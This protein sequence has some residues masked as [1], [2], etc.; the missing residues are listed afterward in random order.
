MLDETRLY[1]SNQDITD[2]R[3]VTQIHSDTGGL[4][5]LVELLAA[6]K[7]SPACRCRYQQGCG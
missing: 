4:P 7:P 3:L 1:L 6:T 5:V 2:E